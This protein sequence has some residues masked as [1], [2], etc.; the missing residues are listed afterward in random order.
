MVWPLPFIQGGLEET[1]VH[2]MEREYQKD[3]MSLKEAVSE[4]ANMINH[5]KRPVV[6]AG[7]ELHRYKMKNTFL[8]RQ[9][10]AYLQTTVPPT[11][12]FVIEIPG[13]DQVAIRDD[14]A[15]QVDHRRRPPTVHR[16]LRRKTVPG[17]RPQK[18]RRERLCPSLGRVAHWYVFVSKLTITTALTYNYDYRPEYRRL[19]SYSSI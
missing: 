5:A 10:L 15:G 18:D 9:L 11:D 4:A 13:E 12:S 2:L 1:I 8:V 16:S 19:L 6:I 7:V 17:V 3:Q 14:D